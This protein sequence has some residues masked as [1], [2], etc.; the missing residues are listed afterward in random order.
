MSLAS[1]DFPAP[2]GPTSATRSPGCTVSETSRSTFGPTGCDSPAVSG[3]P[4]PYENATLSTSI[5]PRSGR[6][7]APG[8]SPTVPSVSS[9]ANTLWSAAPA[10][11]TVL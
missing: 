9:S 11:C 7:T 8:F 10:D 2:V 3:G 5:A 6:S 1:V 4:P